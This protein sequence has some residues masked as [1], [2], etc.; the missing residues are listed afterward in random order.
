MRAFVADLDAWSSA[1]K[2]EDARADSEP[3]AFA[4]RD[5]KAGVPVRGATRATVTATGYVAGNPQVILRAF[6]GEN[7]RFAAAF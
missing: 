6:S 2:A 4:P 5:K 1:A 7:L 3:A